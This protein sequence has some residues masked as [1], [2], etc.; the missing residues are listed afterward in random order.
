[1]QNKHL[2][3]CLFVG[4]LC[5]ALPVTAQ[6]TRAEYI[7]KYKDIAISQMYK[8]NIPASIILAQ[9]CLESG[10]GNSTLAL[11]ANNHFGIKCHQWEGDS[12]LHD[13]DSLQEC[14]RKYANPFDSYRDHSEFLKTRPRYSNLFALGREDY[15][16]WAQG[17]KAAGYATNPQYA[18]LLIEIIESNRLYAYDTYPCPPDLEA[19]PTAVFAGAGVFDGGEGNEGI[20][21]LTLGRQIRTVNGKRYVLSEPGDTYALLAKEYQLFTKEITGFNEVP[22]HADLAV[23]ERVFIERKSRA[24]AKGNLSHT[25]S[26]GETLHSLAQRYGIREDA[27]RQRNHLAKGRTLQE[28]DVLRLR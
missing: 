15:K 19:D 28:G 21:L 6:T 11:E 8:Y 2:I 16:N 20:Y 3:P 7:A 18:E 23:G 26:S 12:L 1:M 25:V 13:D 24:A 22:L 27:L 17:L 10:N 4:F 5:T 14:F 9:G